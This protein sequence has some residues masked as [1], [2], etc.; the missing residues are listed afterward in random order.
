MVTNENPE[1]QCY[2]AER[3][4][5]MEANGEATIA[6]IE[7]AWEFGPSKYIDFYPLPDKGIR[8]VMEYVGEDTIISPEGDVQW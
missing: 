1:N 8:V 4:R 2:S 5:E 6:A 7:S 3:L